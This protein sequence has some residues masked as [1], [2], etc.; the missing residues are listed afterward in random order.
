MSDDL[1]DTR[2][3]DRIRH[4]YEVERELAA[5]LRASNRE[6]RTVLFQ[7]L[8]DELFRRVPDHPRLTRRESPEE[9]QRKVAAALRLLKPHLGPDKTLVEFAP[10]DGALADAAAAYCQRVIGIDISDQRANPAQSPSN[11]EVMVYD[12]YHCSL[13]DACADVA[14]SCMFLEHLHPDDLQPHFQLALRLLKP[15]GVYVAWTPHRFAGPHDVSR[16]FGDSLDCFHFQEWTVAG[17]IK[18]MRKS[19]FERFWIYRGGKMWKNPVMNGL[20][21]LAERIWGCM[22][23]F[24]RKPISARCFR[25]VIVA[26]EKKVRV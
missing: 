13:P 24:L 14:F 16:H 3:P 7:S 23:A 1:L 8:Y 17:L 21:L 9:L 2:S 22:P 18:E 26:A 4:H 25:A 5:R 15:G 20:E 11:V 12:G 6:E 10:G 19:G